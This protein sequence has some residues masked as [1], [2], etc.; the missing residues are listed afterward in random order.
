MK[1]QLT[2]AFV[3]LPCRKVFK[4]PSHRELATVIKRW[5]TLQ[6][7]RSVRPPWSELGTRSVRLRRATWPRGR[8][9]S[10]TS[11]EGAHLFATRDSDAL[12]FVRSAIILRR[13]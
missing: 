11:A 4:R 6:Y 5:I 12:Q 10:G 9:S 1:Q 7:A 2:A 3:C 8:K 13:E